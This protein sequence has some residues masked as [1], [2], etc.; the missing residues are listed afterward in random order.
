[1]MAGAYGI[2]TDDYAADDKAGQIKTQANLNSNSNGT[3][4][5]RSNNGAG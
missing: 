1:M 4:G 3:Y 5:P 2:C